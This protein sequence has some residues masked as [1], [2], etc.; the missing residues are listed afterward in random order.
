MNEKE[1]SCVVNGD[2]LSPTKKAKLD[3][4]DSSYQPKIVKCESHGIVKSVA[5]RVLREASCNFDV[6]IASSIAP[7]ANG[8]PD[9]E[10]ERKVMVLYTGGTIGMKTK[11]GVYVPEPN[12][13]PKA[14][15]AVPHLH[16]DE[17]ANHYF[18][19][20][21]VQP[22]VLPSAHG[23][24][25]RI[26]YWLFEYEPLLDSSDMTFDD[27]IK[28]AKDVYRS[29]DNYDGFVILHG[30]DTL[31]YTASALSFMF[32]NL[33]K[34]V[35]LTGA[36]IPVVEVRSDGRENLIG[37]LILAA[38]YDITEVCVYFNNKL[39][40]GNR[41]SKIDNSGLDA[42]NSPN[43][44]ILASIEVKIHVDWDNIFRSSESEK[45]SLQT[46]LNRNVGLLRIFPSI[47]VECIRAFLASPIEGIVLQTFGAGN[48]PSNRK[49]IIDELKKAIDRGAII[50]NCSQ[51][52]RG[53]V[54]AQ[55]HTG[56]REIKSLAEVT[57]SVP[58]AEKC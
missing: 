11:N 13:L 50:V 21:D 34:P 15:R 44:P 39:M 9:R 43:C 38:N 22:Y 30:T 31:S 19:D 25:Y 5:R 55:Y 2:Q 32:E 40:R 23:E 51:C 4:I 35:I 3:P 29:Y 17:Y 49:D 53:Q 26:V 56:A 6:A 10:Q 54:D 8:K 1:C 33:S 18:P 58:G 47:S 7:G 24:K 41:S 37:A 52:Y 36:Q 12:Y 16:D 27:W 14:I 46:H 57:C 48:I 42:F 45:V 20:L 28:I